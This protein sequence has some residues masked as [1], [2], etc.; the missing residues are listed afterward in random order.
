VVIEQD[1]LSC[2][3]LCLIHGCP[4]MFTGDRTEYVRPGSGRWRT[5]AN[6]DQQ[7]WKACW[8]QP[9][10]SSNPASSA[11]LSCGDAKPLSFGLAAHRSLGHSFV[12]VVARK[13]ARNGP[14]HPIRRR[15][16]KIRETAKGRGGPEAV[17]QF[18]SHSPSVR[19][20]SGV[21]EGLAG[22]VDRDRLRPRP[23][24]AFLSGGR[25]QGCY[26]GD[27]RRRGVL[28]QL[29]ATFEPCILCIRDES[30][31]H[32]RPHQSGLREAGLN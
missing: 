29:P 14:A 6:G 19:D 24:C 16:H 3:S 8:G 17:A 11:T 22:E 21:C 25:H 26:G 27:A 10:A 15:S 12:S 1:Y 30:R 23:Q 20:R 9:L 28:P 13:P 2:L 4:R 32:G 31:N 18:V 5:M 7:C